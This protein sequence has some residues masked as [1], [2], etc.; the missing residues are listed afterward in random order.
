MGSLQR[1]N[2]LS[3]L[4]KFGRL[5]IRKIKDGQ[6]QWLEL[7]MENRESDSDPA[8]MYPL[9]RRLKALD[10]DTKN[11]VRA[12]V[13][14]AAIAGIHDFLFALESDHND[15]DDE[16]EI[17]VNGQNIVDLSEDGLHYE[18]FFWDEDFSDYPDSRKAKE[19]KTGK[20]DPDAGQA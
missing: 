16:I 11:I 14:S 3:D 20:K 10:E 6:L 9:Y 15:G 13:T 8:L 1:R 2:R 19:L 5:A 12:A 7:A 4:D 18:V 17:L